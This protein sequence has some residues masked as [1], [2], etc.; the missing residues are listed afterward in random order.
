MIN[1]IFKPVFAAV[2][3]GLLAA[4]AGTGT[5]NV[6]EINNLISSADGNTAIVARNTGF[7]GSA[8][9]IFV[10]MDGEQV[11][12]LGNNEVGTFKAT[13]G[14]HTLSIKF[15]GP[16]IGLKTNTLTYVND[17]KRPQYFVITLTQNFFGAEMTISEVSAQSFPS[18][19]N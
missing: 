4:C 19:I 6:A 10:L 8:P 14:T 2:L 17:P 3:L 16:A 12:A 13:P 7:A 18:A 15:E 1:R 5:T 9:R 11:A